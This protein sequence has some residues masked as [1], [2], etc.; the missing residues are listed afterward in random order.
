MVA[1]RSSARCWPCTSPMRSCGSAPRS[2]SAS[3]SA[4]ATSS[5]LDSAT[6]GTTTNDWRPAAA[7][8]AR[9][10]SIFGSARRSRISVRIGWRPGGSS[11]IVLIARSP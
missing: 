9:K 4:L 3:A 1:S 2:R 7:S 6:S 10:A 5:A 8:S 11:R